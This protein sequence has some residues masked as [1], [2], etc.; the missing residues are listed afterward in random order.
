VPTHLKDSVETIGGIVRLPTKGGPGKESHEGQVPGGRPDRRVR[1][2]QR[3]RRR[4]AVPIRFD[5]LGGGEGYMGSPKNG[6][7]S[8]MARSSQIGQGAEMR[9]QGD[10]RMTPEFE[11]I[12][13][14]GVEVYVI[15]GIGGAIRI[16]A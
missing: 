15:P 9:N 4:R 13:K 10:I 3:K 8:W 16:L 1:I 7:S 2:S 6:T 11:F 5:F 12:R 14:R